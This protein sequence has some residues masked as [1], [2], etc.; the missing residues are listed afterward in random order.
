MQKRCRGGE[1]EIYIKRIYDYGYLMCECWFV[2]KIQM[3]LCMNIIMHE[4]FRFTSTLWAL[5]KWTRVHAAAPFQAWHPYQ[6]SSGS[7]YSAISLKQV[8]EN[9][10]Y[11]NGCLWLRMSEWM[12]LLIPTPTNNN[13]TEDSSVQLYGRE[14]GRGRPCIAGN[15]IKWHLNAI[16]RVVLLEELLT[17]SKRTGCL[18]YPDCTLYMPTCPPPPP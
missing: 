4:F 14:P 13:I 6:K 7:F 5:A 11:T 10:L 17:G 18:L 12:F 15:H 16:F 8:E 3:A 1:T 9:F 2:C